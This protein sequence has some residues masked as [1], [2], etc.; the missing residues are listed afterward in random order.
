M[1]IQEREH[2][3]QISIDQLRRRRWRPDALVVSADG[4]TIDR[5]TSKAM[6]SVE[7]WA[8]YVREDGYAL[9][10]TKEFMAITAAMY[11]GQWLGAIEREIPERAAAW[12]W[13]ARVIDRDVEM[14]LGS[15]TIDGEPLSHV[16]DLPDDRSIEGLRA[17]LRAGKHGPG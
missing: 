17:W 13:T 14:H 11:E 10:T 3:L 5:P 8:I 16:A 6:K 9:G 12:W 1:P 15:F 7:L 4:D 2:L